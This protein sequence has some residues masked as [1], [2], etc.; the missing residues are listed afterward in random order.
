MK[1]WGRKG[2]LEI[3][4]RSGSSWLRRPPEGR[5][6]PFGRKLESTRT[7]KL[8]PNDCKRGRRVC[9]VIGEESIMEILA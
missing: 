3:S 8:G 2:A 6:R 5:D 1:R 7:H 4:Q 9:T